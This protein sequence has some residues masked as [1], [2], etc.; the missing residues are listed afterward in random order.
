MTGA[1][2]NGNFYLTNSVNSAN[3]VNSVN[4]KG[5]IM[6]PIDIALITATLLCSLVAGFLIAFSIVVMPGIATLSDLDFLR[7]FKAIDRVIQNNQPIFIVIWLGSA[8]AVIASAFISI[9][10]FA[11]IDRILIITAAI[12]YTLGVQLPTITINIPLNNQLQAQDLEKM[13]QSELSEVRKNF[14]PLWLRWNRIR[15]FIATLT[16]VILIIVCLRIGG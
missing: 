9:W 8:L 12:I 16:S 2:E 1:N 10:Q 5:E 4:S 6:E 11:G 15:T 14:E 3:S 13:P 7:A